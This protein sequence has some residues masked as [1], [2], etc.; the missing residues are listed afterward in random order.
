MLHVYQPKDASLCLSSRRVVFI[1]D[2]V[3]RTLF[4]QFAHVVDPALPSFP[5][6]DEQKHSDY[7]FYSKSATQLSFYWDPFLNT[8]RTHGFVNQSNKTGDGYSTRR[9]AL[10]VF[11]SGLWYLRYSFTSG[12]LLAWEAKME[13]ILGNFNQTGFKPADEVVI[14]PIE[15]VVPSKLSH[16]RAS[17]MRSSDIEAMN[18]DL[19]HRIHPPQADWIHMFTNSP[20]TLPVSFPLTF[21]GMLDDS[22]TEDGLHFSDAVVKAQANILLNLRCNDILPKKF[23]FDKTCCR[24]YPWPSALHLLV[25]LMATLCAPVVWF[26]SRQG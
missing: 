25:L 15:Q 7:E 5:P 12:G 19:L 16:E 6:D 17:S 3:T 24:R 26:L 9:P 10:L 2:S 21:N 8:S 20:Q 14:L 22:Q 18:A 13:A 11:G 1:G 23:P 4:F